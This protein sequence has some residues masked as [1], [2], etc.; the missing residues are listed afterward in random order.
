[1][2]HVLL[3]DVPGGN[4]FTVLEDAVALGHRVSFVSG[5]L[6]HY[7]AQGAATG[8]SLALAS[9]CAGVTPFTYEALE[10]AVLAI[11]AEDPIDAVICLIDIRLI[12]AAR[13]AAR[14][15]LRFLSPDTACLMRDK[16]A[17]RRRLAEKSVRQPAFALA[18]DAA[19]IVAAVRAI[20]FPT[21]VKPADG[22]G[23]QDIHLIRTEA[24]LAAL[25]SSVAL[26]ALRPTDYGL[27]VAASG[28]YSIERYVT[29]R[30]I[31][32]DVFSRDGQRAFIGI[33]DKRMFPPP[34]FAIRGSCFPSAAYDRDA[35]E[36]YAFE[37]LDAV[38]FDCGAAHIEMIVADDGPHLV[39][40][41]PRL[42][43]AQIPHQM[44]YALGRSLYADLIALHLGEPFMQLHHVEPDAYAAIRWLVADRPGQ[45]QD[46]GFPQGPDPAIKRVVCFKGQGDPVRPPLN[47]G[48]RIAYVIA[49]GPT[50]PDAEASADAYIASTTVAVDIAP[51]GCG[52]SLAAA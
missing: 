13:I 15:G 38:G 42:V 35:I 19:G 3:F 33:N 39:E 31:G 20:G 7:R 28:R 51:V 21:V 49:T 2:A 25:T 11:H 47:N 48:D 23:S 1:M 16:A 50:Q 44:G 30:M 5:H 32:C 41:N 40:V 27:G 10:R 29:G 8:A 46:I 4:D 34:S 14:L 52:S 43:S 6:D 37:I 45:L 18:E 17:V 24:D 36:R 9:R 26:A 12:E 22:Y